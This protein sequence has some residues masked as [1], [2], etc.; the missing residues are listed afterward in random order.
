MSIS[1]E[2]LNDAITRNGLTGTDQ[3]IADAL[4]AGERDET[5]PPI[6]YDEIT[7]NK[8]ITTTAT[9]KLTVK[10]LLAD[11]NI[12]PVVKEVIETFHISMLGAGARVGKEQ[13]W[14]DFTTMRAVLPDNAKA[15]I[16]I[17]QSMATRKDFPDDEIT[18]LDVVKAKLIK[19]S[20]EMLTIESTAVLREAEAKA[21][22]MR[23]AKVQF[24]NAIH[25][26]DGTG[27]S[28][29]VYDGSE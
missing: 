20:E 10:A 27:D 17:L 11:E 6:N 18:A 12:D 3:E 15:V 13:I 23:V 25:A 7:L 5:S 8:G 22:R 4:N 14:N 9:I 28:P 19:M 21:E 2:H 26:W 29:P 24:T 16:D 1:P